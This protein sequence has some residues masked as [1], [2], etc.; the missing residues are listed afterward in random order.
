MTAGEKGSYVIL[1]DRRKIMQLND[2]MLRNVTN[3]HTGKVKSF[4]SNTL[5]GL[6]IYTPA[7]ITIRRNAEETYRKKTPP[8][9]ALIYSCF[10]SPNVSTN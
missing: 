3:I 2:M 8:R 5:W 1:Q 7:F 6:K 9:P 10:P 4:P